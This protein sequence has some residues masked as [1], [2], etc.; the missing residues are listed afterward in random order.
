MKS[1]VPGPP[2]GNPR[3]AAS[4]SSGARLNSAA[5][6]RLNSARIFH[7][8]RE[9]PG[10]S[11]RGLAELTGLDAATISSIVTRLEV[12]GILQR[13]APRRSGQAGR[14]ESLLAIAQDA[15]LLIGAGLEPD[16]ISLI[17]A[18]LDGARRMR[19]DLPGTAD[20]AEAVAALQHG[21]TELLIRCAMP[22]SR[23]RGI[24]IGIPGLLDAR[25]HLVLAPN[26]GWRDLPMTAM[27]RAAFSAP[28]QI[29]ND[30]KAAALAERIFGSVRGVAD[31]V[32]I[33]GNAGIG[34]GLYLGG[35]LYRGCDGLAGELGHMK[36]V[37][38][39]RLC[40]CGGRGCLEAYVSET[41]IAARLRESGRDLPDAALVAAAA[42]AGDAVVLGVLEE[43]GGHLG[44]AL[45]NLVNLVNPR[46]VVLGGNLA[47]LA[48]YLVPAARRVLAAN[49][50]PVMLEDAEMLVSP[51]GAEA[52]PM[53]G[54]ALALELFQPRDQGLSPS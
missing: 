16:G 46:A 27:L 25:G 53:G 20:P 12:E 35:R 30:A 5:I 13:A 43:A 52:V 10:S 7:A 22:L 34:G 17:A 3:R 2:E 51:L 18:S 39:G 49:G 37:P 44:A 26:L 14:P 42:E 1:P 38:G 36:L 31:F 29:D 50:L 9:H 23:L 41:A 33:Y 21:V 32:F 40:G 11:Q 4:E 8:L 28:V 45:A 15:G 48:T 24:G 6:R 47:T 19:L 54:V